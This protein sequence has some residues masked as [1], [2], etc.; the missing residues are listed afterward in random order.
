AD[1][2]KSPLSLVLVCAVS[3]KGGGFAFVRDLLDLLS[4]NKRETDI[5]GYICKDR[6]G[7]LLP[8]TDEQGVRA[9]VEGVA[10][11]TA[12]YPLSLS[13]CTYPHH[14][15]ESLMSDARDVPDTL[16]YFF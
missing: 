1:R 15:F 5:I 13:S 9:F 11:R 10:R 8:H 2:T 3:D 7:L 12:E 4:R 14:L 16:T 6:I